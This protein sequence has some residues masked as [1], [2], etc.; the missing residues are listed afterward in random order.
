MISHFSFYDMYSI[1]SILYSSKT[2]VVVSSFV[3]IFV[4]GGEG[5]NHKHFLVWRKKLATRKL[6]EKEK[7]HN[8]GQNKNFQFQFLN[9]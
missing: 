3:C 7:V 9:I 2:V 5:G 8:V 4:G 1:Y 6:W